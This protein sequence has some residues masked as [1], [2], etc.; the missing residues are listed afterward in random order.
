MVCRIIFIEILTDWGES[1]RLK[2]L[3]L[4]LILPP[5][6][7][8]FFP[9]FP[10][11]WL[12]KRGFKRENKMQMIGLVSLVAAIDLLESLSLFLLIFIYPTN[13]H[14][15]SWLKTELPLTKYY[16][17]GP[18]ILF[19]LS[20][21]LI[22]AI[23]NKFAIQEQIL[24]TADTKSYYILL[25]LSWFDIIDRMTYPSIYFEIHFEIF[26]SLFCPWE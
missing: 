21:S 24:Q 17:F 13:V 6:I 9:G 12:V 16:I 4:H 25:Y 19:G 3:W 18:A 14:I 11:A 20:I 10:L 2:K 8:L 23:K 22:F 15:L 1:G 7:Y 26:Q 5:I